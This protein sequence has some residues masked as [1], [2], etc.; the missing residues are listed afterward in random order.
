MDKKSAE[1][2]VY[3]SYLKAIKYQAYDT[4]DENKR[5]PIYSR[6]VIR[7]KSQT[8]CVLVTGSKGKGSVSSMVSHILQTELEVG[9][10][11]SPHIS[12]FC[13]R[14]RVNG[15]M[16]SDEEFIAQIEKIIP[17]FDMIDAHIPNDRFISPMGI[18]ATL[19]LN[20]FNEKGT[21]FNVF[22]CG[23]GAQ[24]DDVN[25]VIHQ[26]A[27]INSIFLEHT[28]E[29]GQTLEEIA[30]DKSHVISGEQKCIYVAEQ[31]QEVLDV[32]RSR[33]S[34]Y[35]TQVKIYGIDFRCDN[36]RYTH[37]GMQ[38]DVIIKDE[39]FKD[40]VVPLLGEHQAKN[41]ALA[42]T[43]CKDILKTFNVDRIKMMLKSFCWPGR[44]EII[45]TNPFIMLDACI[46]AECTNN[47]KETLNYLKI[48]KYIVIVGIPNDKDYV[49]VVKSMQNNAEEIILTKSQNP[50]YVFTKEQQQVLAN[51]GIK[52]TWSS[53]VS[54]AIGI[55]KNKHIPI[56]ILGTTSVVSDVK[57]YF[58]ENY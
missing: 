34:L 42:M 24:Y 28:R 23:K 49:N 35:N 51:Y 36:I 13:E 48:Y 10:M 20:Y 7:E 37:Q 58:E 2:Y 21:Q 1:D 54:E 26:Y 16:I 22:E 33:A 41:C 9:L 25:N 15:V 3:K 4:K 38:F 45:S 32:I 27:I 50:H 12:D 44:M 6:D 40:I 17:I 14:F 39:I 46:N 55:A 30:L 52:T 57:S 43:I 29:L 11:T 47:V 18:Q 8:P 5:N 53:S 56:V 19:A 31:K